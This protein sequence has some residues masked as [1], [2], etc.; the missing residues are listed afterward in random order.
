[1]GYFYPATDHGTRYTQSSS[2]NISLKNVGTSFVSLGNFVT[3][4]KQAAS[5]N[6]EVMLNSRVRGGIFAGASGVLF[7]VRIDGATANYDN[8]A[9]IT[10]SNT[11]DFVSINAIF[12]GLSAG[13]HTVSIWAR[14]GSGTS[15]GVFLDP[16]GWGG[17]I[18]VKETY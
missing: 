4:T 16:G 5:S 6:V 8:E 13:T 12:T 1:M 18:I 15:N 11:S 10:A 9:A 14:T 3:F 7:Q 2:L 17:R